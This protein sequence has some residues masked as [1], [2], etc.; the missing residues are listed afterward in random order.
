M[1]CKIL[2][3]KYNE[4]ISFRVSHKKRMF[5]SRLELEPNKRPIIL[6]NNLLR[7]ITIETI[8]NK[9]NVQKDV[10]ENREKKKETEE[11]SQCRSKDKD[12][13]QSSNDYLHNNDLMCVSRFEMIASHYMD[14]DDDG[15]N[16]NGGMLNDLSGIWC[17]RMHINSAKCDMSLI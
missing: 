5:F 4:R 15:S 3:Y 9:T 7:V 8:L 11:E 12:S 16:N 13:K 6:I 14:D 10:K 2:R 1:K 17:D